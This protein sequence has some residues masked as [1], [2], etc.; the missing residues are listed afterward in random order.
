MIPTAL[1][2]IETCSNIGLLVSVAELA[3]HLHRRRHRCRHY[4]V[5]EFR[6]AR[7]SQS[8]VHYVECHSLHDG[9]T[10]SANDLM[11]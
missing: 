8:L 11:Y 7:G 3:H 4:H 1:T 10:P 2:K 5:Y 9:T 6:C